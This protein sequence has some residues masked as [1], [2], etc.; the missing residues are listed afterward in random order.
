M[1]PGLTPGTVPVARCRF[2][3]LSMQA[4][5]TTPAQSRWHP[6]GTTRPSGRIAH[7]VSRIAYRPP[8]PDTVQPTLIP[9]EGQSPVD[10]RSLV[11]F[12]MATLLLIVFEYWGLP[13]DFSGSW[14]HARVAEWLG[15]G[16]AQYHDLLPYQFWGVSSLVL[17]VGVPLLVIRFV[18]GDRPYD[19][20][21]RIRGQWRKF[22]PYAIG[23]GCMVPIL[24]MV[25]LWPAFQA[26][27]P[28][29][30]PAALG[31]WHFWGW[32]LFYGMQFLGLET[33]FRGFILFGLYPRLGYYAIPVMVIPYVMI[34][35]GKP[36]PETFA[37]IVAGFVLGWLALRSKSF[38][39]G[40]FLHWGVALTMDVM[41]IG[42][43]LGFSTVLHRVF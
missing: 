14:F 4:A 1:L 43:E 26:K 37:A 38:L 18:I 5:A 9:A 8:V 42:H 3:F 25:S 17:R 12:I 21:F 31:G 41:V 40:W 24:F 16:Y 27:Y 7:R 15:T 35:F 11:V 10:R 22:R 36:Y 19:W 34:H 28:F 29:Y 20:G 33:F 32:E 13:E 39:W 23:F 30:H 6:R 2:P